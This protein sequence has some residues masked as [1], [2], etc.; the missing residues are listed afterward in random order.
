MPKGSWYFR[1][2][3]TSKESQ[4]RQVR[5]RAETLAKERVAESIKSRSAVA[6]TRTPEMGRSPMWATPRWQRPSV[7]VDSPDPA[8]FG[9][10]SA[11]RPGLIKIDS[12]ATRRQAMF[13]RAKEMVRTGRSRA[14]AEHA[15]QMHTP[16]SPH[17]DALDATRSGS[18]DPK[19]GMKTM[20]YAPSKPGSRTAS[21][22]KPSSGAFPKVSGVSASTLLR[23]TGTVMSVL[24]AVVSALRGKNP[25]DAGPA[26]VKVNGKIQF[27]GPSGS[28]WD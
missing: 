17:R 10:G 6:Q 9:G 20:P 1:D 5:S 14:M 8:R 25:I 21:P 2:D 19:R 24:P 7:G 18:L 12:K 22:P 16:G 4:L 23:G 27:G 15:K 28:R 26:P 3:P 13:E 11:N